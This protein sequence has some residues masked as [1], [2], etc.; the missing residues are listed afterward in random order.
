MINVFSKVAAM[1]EQEARRDAE[2]KYSPDFDQTSAQTEPPVP[3]NVFHS[4]LKLER[5]R[6]ER[7]GKKFVLMLIDANL[8]NGS[9]AGI[10][11]EA[12]DVIVASKRETDLIGW[13]KGRPFLGVIFPE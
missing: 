13:V 3:E 9:A 10:L 2:N 5:R 7:S 1:H 8:E 11:K 12:G 4:M 6:A